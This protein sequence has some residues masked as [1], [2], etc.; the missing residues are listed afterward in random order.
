MLTK[1][2]LHAKSYVT[3]YKKKTKK[4]MEGERIIAQ[5]KRGIKAKL[6]RFIY[7]IDIF[8]FVPVREHIPGCLCTDGEHIYYNPDQLMLVLK[9][10]GK[11]VLEYK[12]AHMTMHGMLRHFE[13]REQFRNEKLVS[14]IMDAQV[15]VML[16]KM[17]VEQKED[18]NP[19]N[20]FKCE[21][22]AILQGYSEYYRAL[23][24]KKSRNMWM[25]KTEDY[26]VDDHD[27]WSKDFHDYDNCSENDG[28][29]EFQQHM[30][31]KQSDN[32]M[33][34]AGELNGIKDKWEKA[35]SIIM[36]KDTSALS[37]EECIQKILEQK[38]SHI[39]GSGSGTFNKQVVA[40]TGNGMNYK[41]V[42]KQFIKEKEK[43]RDTT[44]NFDVMLYCYGLELYDDVPLVEPNEENEVKQINSI[45]IAIDTSG[46]CD[47]RIAKLFV[48][49]IG[50][51]FRD[52][53]QTVT[54]TSI[55][56]MECDASIQREQCITAIDDL[57]IG[58]GLE[59]H[60]F[61]GTDFV[62]VFSRVE[63]LK[64]EDDLK[65]DALI[66]LTDTLGTFPKKQPDYPVF[67]VI[68]KGGL[69]K[70]GHPFNRNIPQWATWLVMD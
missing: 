35:R 16:E 21:T 29:Q 41:E 40:A 6:Y 31:G 18:I 56:L 45:V 66:Y 13:E 32:M 20:K 23:R 48:R 5:I 44:D 28:K 8:E 4:V 50:N 62:P 47:G 65:V 54:F 43:C 59:L 51:I 33:K 67:L 64:R 11:E 38:H 58:N 46:S 30:E 42:M 63:E 3:P 52:I 27:Y 68:P 39:V 9:N 12:L 36:G 55:Y 22:D 14:V 57:T 2:E 26:Y 19:H 61:G 60:G 34:K 15:K 1:L 70:T 7:A 37:D 53:K 17:G 69:D 24:S 10:S 49:E 25:E